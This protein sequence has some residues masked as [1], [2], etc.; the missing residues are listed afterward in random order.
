MKTLHIKIVSIYSPHYDDMC[1]LVEDTRIL[2]IK[3]LYYSPVDQRSLC[4]IHPEGIKHSSS[5]FNLICLNSVFNK[6]P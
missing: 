5:A 6:Q 2:K 3:L 1:F 4:R